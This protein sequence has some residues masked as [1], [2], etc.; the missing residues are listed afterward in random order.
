MVDE[1]V[2]IHVVAAES[3]VRIAWLNDSKTI[4]ALDALVFAV[5]PDTL[6][7]AL[8][9]LPQTRVLFASS[10]IML[11]LVLLRVSCCANCNRKSDFFHTVFSFM[12]FWWIAPD[13]YSD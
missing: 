3:L 5:A 1:V 11:P 8:P 6:L 2:K 12:S 13:S 9:R 4:L 7:P 10:S